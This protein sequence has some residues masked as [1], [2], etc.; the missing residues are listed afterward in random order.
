MHLK[1]QNNKNNENSYFFAWI[2][3]MIE[4]NDFNQLI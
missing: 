2:R 4:I 3:I 1:S